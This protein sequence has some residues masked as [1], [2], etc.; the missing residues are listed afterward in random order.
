ME[1]EKEREEDIFALHAEVCKTFTNE[2]RLKIIDY[3]RD[4]EKSVGE[5]TEY[6]GRKQPVVSQNLGK[7][8][9]KNVVETRRDGT[10]IYYSI[11]DD[12]IFEAFDLI[13]EFIKHNE[14]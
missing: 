4:G 14:I 5:I 8:R 11:S 1:E 9:E 12:R 2:L 10:R 7:M 3:L 6:L 13:R